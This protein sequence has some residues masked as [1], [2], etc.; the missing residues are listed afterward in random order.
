MCRNKKT[1][2]E[3]VSLNTHKKIKEATSRYKKKRTRIGN[4]MDINKKG[5]VEKMNRSEKYIK[6]L[7]ENYE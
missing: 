7:L 1:G 3:H 5:D 4:K 2:K 6:Q